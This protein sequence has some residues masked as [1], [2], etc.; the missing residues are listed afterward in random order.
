MF[1]MV[2]IIFFG[3]HSFSRQLRSPLLAQHGDDVD[4][5]VVAARGGGVAHPD[6]QAH[7]AGREAVLVV[8]MR[9]GTCLVNCVNG[10]L[11]CP[12]PMGVHHSL[13]AGWRVFCGHLC[14]LLPGGLVCGH[15][16][17][18]RHEATEEGVAV[19]G[20]GLVDDLDGVAEDLVGCVDW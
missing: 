8:L 7:A 1:Q 20:E 19:V 14:G 13:P 3:F 11:E 2:L 9:I 4:A 15:G 17:D 12:R 18:W 10:G 5:R 16:V 6:L